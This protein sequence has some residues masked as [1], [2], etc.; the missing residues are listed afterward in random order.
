MRRIQDKKH[1]MGTLEI[2]KTSLS[3]FDAK[4]FLLNNGIHNW[5]FS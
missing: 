5:L 3:F 1:K 4:R 2:N